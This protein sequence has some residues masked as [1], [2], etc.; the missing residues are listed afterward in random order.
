MATWCVTCGLRI[1]RI[2]LETSHSLAESAF[3]MDV[4]RGQVSDLENQTKFFYDNPLLYW[5]QL[6]TC[7]WITLGRPGLWLFRSA[8][9]VTWKLLLPQDTLQI[10]SS[11][12][13]MPTN[14]QTHRYISLSICATHNTTEAHLDCTFFALLSNKQWKS[15]QQHP[16]RY[17]CLRVIS[18]LDFFRSARLYKQSSAV[19]FVLN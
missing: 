4:T 19:A 11:S 1:L 15:S 17:C 14:F 5:Y 7:L 13:N 18:S 12:W 6:C 8:P 16:P 9:A 10:K 3:R 2:S